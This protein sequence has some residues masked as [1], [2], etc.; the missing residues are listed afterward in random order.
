MH[1]AVWGRERVR[2]RVRE[3]ERESIELY[4][5]CRPK[6]VTL[7]GLRNVEVDAL[8]KTGVQLV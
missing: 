6:P 1:A 3:R 2:E 8:K 7:L 5:V 4:I